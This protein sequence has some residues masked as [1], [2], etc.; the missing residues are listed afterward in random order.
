MYTAFYGLFEKPFSL[1]PDPRYLFFADSHREALAHL[2]YGIAQG[3][4]FI[5]VTGEVG[6][7]KST[8][9]RALIEGLGPETEVAFLFNPPRSATEL[10]QAIA[11]EYGLDPAGYQRHGLNN[12]LNQFLLERKRNGQQVLLV[13]DEAQNLDAH[14]LEEIRLL[15]NLETANSKL[16]QI[17]LLGQPELDR[18]LDSHEL[19]Q[20]RQRISVRWFLTPLTKLETGA[21][22]AHRLYVSAGDKRS[23]FTPGAM[24]EIFRRTGGVP[25]RINLLADRSLLAGYGAGAEKIGP[26]IVRQAAHE[27]EAGGRIRQPRRA[28][29]VA[30]RIAMAL[31][32]FAFAA[33]AGNWVGRTDTLRSLVAV[34]PSPEASLS[35]VSA[36]K[37]SAPVEGSLGEKVSS[38]ALAEAETLSELS[39]VDSLESSPPGDSD[40]TTH[41]PSSTDSLR[42]IKTDAPGPVGTRADRLRNT[43]LP[44]SFLGRL[45]DYQDDAAGRAIAL[46][47]ILGS[48]D[49]LP[50]LK[51]PEDEEATAMYL[52][53]RGLSV[54]RVLDATLDE[55]RAL[56]HPVMLTLH[57]EHA[58]LRTVALRNLD[59]ESALLFG[60]TDRDSLRVPILEIENQWTGQALI[61]YETFEQLPASLSLGHSGQG[62][63]WLQAA[64]AEL[65]LYPG[66]PSGEFDDL[67][68]NSVK[69]LQEDALL[70]P[71]GT[72][73]PRTQMLLYSKLSRYPG[74]RLLERRGAG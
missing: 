69:Q 6:T 34:N 48:F 16:I 30:L 19:R 72:V 24:R 68:Q 25:R 4:G 53:G 10:L 5:A 70:D 52:E 61:V 71:D 59:A 9:C 57:T 26:G 64:L 55:L 1:S 45:L 60:V 62:V 38:D 36:A 39:P 74:P 22:V 40:T 23:I 73:G 7:G 33:V 17:V 11:Q 18:K 43:L 21:Y 35:P 50:A 8:L 44:G 12:Q 28:S 51:I 67:T 32:L 15:S 42:G 63:V 31:G 37:A 65:G 47:A 20:L 2:R 66:T 41:V 13:I 27:I 56:D 49:L 3:E 46:N 58:G 54:L 14:V 29:F